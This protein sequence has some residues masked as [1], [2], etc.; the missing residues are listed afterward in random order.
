MKKLGYSIGTM[1]ILLIC[2]FVFVVVPAM[3]KDDSSKNVLTFGTYNGKAITNEPNSKMMNNVAQY[4]QTFNQIG[5]KVSTYTIYEYAFNATVGDFAAEE[6]VKESGYKIPSSAVN[7]ILRRSFADSNGK[8]SEKLYNQTPQ[9]E[10]TKMAETIKTTLIKDRFNADNFGSRDEYVG[11]DALYGIK[12]STAE[13]DFLASFDTTKRSFD[14]IQF[15]LD[16]YPE[17]EKAAYAK[18]HSEKFTKFDMSVITVATQDEANKVLKRLNSEEIVFEDAVQEYSTKSYGNPEGKLTSSYAYQLENMLND[19]NEF[20]ALTV[21][22][23]GELSKPLE[24]KMGYAVFRVDG[25]SVAADNLDEDL[26]TVAYNYL[27]SYETSVIENYF[28]GK[29]NELIA[30]ARVNGIDSAC[31]KAGVTKSTLG[32]FPLNYG[33]VS[34]AGAVPSNTQGLYEAPNSE[35][36][37][38]KAFSTKVGDFSEPVVM[39]EMVIVLNCTS[40]ENVETEDA[41]V[42]DE[43]GSYDQ[44]AA[45]SALMNSPKLKNNFITTYYNNMN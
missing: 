16:D 4:G 30:D 27:S 10:V 1:I 33:N 29:A 41:T 28:I 38:T 3:V 8:F 24:T 31:E 12:E 26:S 34:V 35:D 25:D 13:L 40:E 45:S 36:F 39:S 44:E 18:A 23:K 14:M 11:E 7:R 6:A 22:A 42:L 43:I 17:E 37:L 5:Y 21:L 9:E 32:T 2:A 15:K 19:S 20:L